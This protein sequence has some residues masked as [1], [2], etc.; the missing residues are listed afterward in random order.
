MM[1]A[2]TYSPKIF[3]VLFE[4]TALMAL[5]QVNIFSQKND[6]EIQSVKEQK[7]VC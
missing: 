1:K 3:I 7:A 6:N 4:S 5:G 2:K